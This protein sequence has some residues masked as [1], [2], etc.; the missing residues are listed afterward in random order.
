MLFKYPSD[1]FIEMYYIFLVL[2]AIVLG[3]VIGEYTGDKNLGMITIFGT[4]ITGT[5]LFLIRLS[6]PGESSNES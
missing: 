4:L 6:F 5:S 3:A 1:K 2:A